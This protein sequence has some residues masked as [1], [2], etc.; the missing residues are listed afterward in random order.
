MGNC[1]CLLA[2]CTGGT[3]EGN[4]RETKEIHVKWVYPSTGDKRKIIQSH[5]TILGMILK[6]HP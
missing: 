3:R 2:W 6:E 4:G 1:V 5:H